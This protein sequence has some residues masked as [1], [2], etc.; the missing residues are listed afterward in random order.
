MSLSSP[1]MTFGA[2]GSETFSGTVTGENGNGFPKGT[3]TVQS[4]R[5]HGV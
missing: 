3:V 1:N 5:H 4:R 2:E